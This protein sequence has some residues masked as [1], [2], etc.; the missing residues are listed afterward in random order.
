MS[1]TR[2][3]EAPKRLLPEYDSIL[4]QDL[5]IGRFHIGS[6]N[7]MCGRLRI[8][9]QQ[10]ITSISKT[11]TNIRILD[12]FECANRLYILI[13]SYGGLVHMGCADDPNN[14]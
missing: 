12:R 5:R 11:L 1:A 7:Q 10:M 3:I 13:L 8:M 2:K 14:L 4:G 6:N 9:S